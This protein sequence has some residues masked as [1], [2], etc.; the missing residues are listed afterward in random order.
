[1][2]FDEIDLV[3]GIGILLVIVYHFF[4]DL[5]FF[6]VNDWAFS[7]PLLFIGRLA[8]TIMILISGVALS[9]SIQKWRKRKGAAIHHAKRTML[10][11]A[12]AILITSATFIYPHEGFIFFGI[13]HF[14][15]V[16]SVIGLMLDRFPRIQVAIVLASLPIWLYL[17]MQTSASALLSILGTGTTIYTLDLFSIFP[18]IGVFFLGMLIGRREYSVQGRRFDAKHL[19]HNAVLEWMGRHTLAIYLIHQLVLIGSMMLI[20]SFLQSGPHL[21]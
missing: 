9:I 4:F 10:L 18:W 6:G 16:A 5:T 20:L 1:M 3:R 21:L 2:R 11:G 14:L 17:Q 15:A 19:P 13:I 7:L 8:A 12:V